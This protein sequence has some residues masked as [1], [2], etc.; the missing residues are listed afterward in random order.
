MQVYAIGNLPLIKTLKNLSKWIQNWYAD[1]GS[2]LGEF[3][4]LK[5]WLKLL[6]LEGSK[7]SYYNEV[8]KMVLIVAPEFVE[9]ANK[10]FEEFGI[11]V[12]TGQDFLEAL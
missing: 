7:H 9:Q 10:A 4:N 8:S 11:Q 3:K 1:D 2:C 6:I 5:E 12:L